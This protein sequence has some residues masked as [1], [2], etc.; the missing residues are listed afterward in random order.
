M[1]HPTIAPEDQVVRHL[2]QEIGGHVCLP[3]NCPMSSTTARSV[4]CPETS[5]WRSSLPSK[6]A[7]AHCSARHARV[8][9][10]RVIAERIEG[11]PE[12]LRGLAQIVLD[13]GSSGVLAQPVVLLLNDI[14]GPDFTI[15]HGFRFRPRFRRASE[16]SK[17][18]LRTDSHSSRQETARDAC[19][20]IGNVR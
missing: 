12:C 9:P 2:E 4:P 10:G 16:C 5:H 11:P 8:A 6:E 18:R 7:R 19:A 20:D 1:Y 3:P 17:R 15:F 13:Y 14:K